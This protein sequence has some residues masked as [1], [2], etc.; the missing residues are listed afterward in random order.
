MMSD[1]ENIKQ[2]FIENDRFAKHNG[3]RLIEASMGR[4]VVEMDVQDFHLNAASV[5]HGAAMFTLADFAFAVACNM[6]GKLSLAV[7]IT[8]NFVKAATGG[9]LRAVCEEISDGKMA[10]YRATVTDESGT[11]I[12]TFEGL[13]FRKNQNLPCLDKTNSE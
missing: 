7:N 6:Q 4:A 11:V 9:T 13:A 12:A 2:F 5:V 10:A 1:T 3:I 8:M